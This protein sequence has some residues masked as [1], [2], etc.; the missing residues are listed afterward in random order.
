M[1]VGAVFGWI[2]RRF[3]RWKRSS[4]LKRVDTAA[5]ISPAPPPPRRPEPSLLPFQPNRRELLPP[6]STKTSLTPATPDKLGGRAHQL[7]GSGRRLLA[8][9]I[10]LRP[11]PRSCVFCSA[12]PQQVPAGLGGLIR[13]QLAA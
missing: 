1:S 10:A 13:R 12:Q 3:P 4:G 11:Q 5:G 6:A 2:G 9:V 7:T 8:E